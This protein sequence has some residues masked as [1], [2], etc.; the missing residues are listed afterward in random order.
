MAGEGSKGDREAGAIL[1]HVFARPDLLAQALTHPSVEGRENY[2]R[3]E[4]LGDRV[5]AVVIAEMLFKHYPDA[6]EGAL[7][8]RFNDLV[9]RDTL[10][11]V[12]VEAGLGGHIILSPAEAESGG[13]EK[14]AIL[15]DVCEAVIAALYLDGGM[16]VAEDFIKSFWG[17]LA[18]DMAETPKDGKT[19]LQERAQGAGLAAP[20]YLEVGRSGPAH[21]PEFTIEVQVKGQASVTGAGRTKQA[22]QQAAAA[23]MLEA[24]SDA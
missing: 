16:A 10:A 14:P 6:R 11:G 3:L 7:A 2:Q 5:L 15:A 22:A 20:V 1:G 13:R 4:F 23:A 8:A 24:W 12:A 18:G 17:A 21:A 19:A 9:R